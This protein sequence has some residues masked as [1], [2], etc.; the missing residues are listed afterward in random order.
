MYTFVYVHGHLLHFKSLEYTHIPFSYNETTDTL[1][2]LIMSTSDALDEQIRRL[3]DL[4]HANARIVDRLTRTARAIG[5]RAQ[6]IVQDI[7]P[8]GVAQENIAGT[9]AEMAKAERCYRPPPCLNDVLARRNTDP[10]DVVRTMDYLIYTHHYLTAPAHTKANSM[11]STYNCYTEAMKHRVEQQLPEVMAAAEAVVRAALVQARTATTA[12]APAS[13][14]SCTASTVF[15][16][17]PDALRH[18]A[19]VVRRLGENF[20]RAEALHNILIDEMSEPLARVARRRCR[21]EDTYVRPPRRVSEGAA[22]DTARLTHHPFASTSSAWPTHREPCCLDGEDEYTP[23]LLSGSTT[24]RSPH[25]HRDVDAI[26]SV[27]AECRAAVRE[28]AAALDASVLTPLHHDYAVVDVPGELAEVPLRVVLTRM[29]DAIQFSRTALMQQPA[30][31]LLLVLRGQDVS[32]FLDAALTSGKQSMCNDMDSNKDRLGHSHGSAG[33]SRSNTVRSSNMSA[34]RTL[35]EVMLSALSFV[36]ELWRWRELALHMPAD[37]QHLLDLVEQELRVF[38]TDVRLLFSD[39]VDAKGR[40]SRPAI[41]S[42]WTRLGRRLD[43]MP[44][45]DAAV[46]EMTIHVFHLHKTLMQERHYRTLGWVLSGESAVMRCCGSCDENDTAAMWSDASVCGDTTGADAAVEDYVVRGVVATLHDVRAIAEAAVDVQTASESHGHSLRGGA[47]LDG[48]DK[49]S[50]EGTRLSV[51]VFV[52]NNVLFLLHGYRREACFYSPAAAGVC[53]SHGVS[54][55]AVAAPCMDGGAVGTGCN[56]SHVGITT[57]ATLCCSAA[58]VTP[59]A[60]V[61]NVS[62]LPAVLL[63]LDDETERCVDEFAQAWERLFP[64]ILGD[65]RLDRISRDAAQP[66]RKGE[67]LAVKRWYREASHALQRRIRDCSREVVI[68][69]AVRLRFIEAAVTTVQRQLGAMDDVLQGRSWSDHPTRWMP[70]TV[71]QWVE[72]IE[73]I[74]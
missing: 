10:T 2:A 48:L 71:E 62:R 37:S 27:S 21:A 36:E 5:T 11:G 66:L 1:S 59:T 54:G 4:A 28:M 49:E 74:F 22:C 16:H 3:Q 8:W 44:A 40:L 58:S 51:E 41:V 13:S 65:A 9:M 34:R 57:T 45:Q 70:L 39:Y 32:L 55:D 7:Q 25:A 53:A 33:A 19:P 15:M 35:R 73:K 68:D 23:A 72:Q 69:V 26:R 50:D 24:A 38:V 6:R 56:M 64:A 14:C 29:R 67:R 42:A 12:S 31:T 63:L 47:L 61:S 52:V 20:H 46:Y 43:W 30:R 60:A 18:V 17:Q